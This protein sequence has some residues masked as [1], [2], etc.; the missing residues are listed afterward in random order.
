MNIFILNL[1]IIILIVF[2][3]FSFFIPERLKVLN[4]ANLAFHTAYDDTYSFNYLCTYQF[5]ACEL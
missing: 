2:N 5:W 1:F 3:F 4:A